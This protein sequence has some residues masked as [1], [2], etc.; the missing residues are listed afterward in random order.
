MEFD[1]DIITIAEYYQKYS[2]LAIIDVRSPGEF[3]KGHI[4]GAT[5]IPLFSDAER[6]MVGTAYVRQSKEIAMNIGLKIVKPKLE[7]FIEESGKV[8]P[9]GEVVVHCWRGGLRSLSFARHL[10]ENGFHS[11]RVIEGGYKSFRNYVLRFFDYPFKLT[12]LGGYTGSGKTNILKYFQEQSLQVVDLE[13]V[14]HHRGSA[15]GGIEMGTQPT[16]E[17]FENNLFE[18]MRHLN[19]GQPIWMEDENHHIGSVFIPL[20]L[21]KQIE[22]S[23]VYFLDIKKEKRAEYLVQEY[24]GLDKEELA[25]AIRKI[26]KRLG[27]D[28]AKKAL[29]YLEKN[30]FYEVAITAL[31]YYDMYYLGGLSLRE[32]GSIHRLESDEV[33]TQKNARILLKA[34]SYE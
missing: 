10:S 19:L 4:P 27:Y 13:G 8:A 22:K 31:T 12:I 23:E 1:P 14:A 9:S 32:A 17:Q 24:A 15:F 16:G 20:G 30:N 6:A 2:H 29:E 28:R 7:Y 18:K 25:L 11:I 5:N 21:F 3:T 26:T 34:A 33:N